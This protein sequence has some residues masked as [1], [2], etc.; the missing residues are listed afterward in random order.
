MISFIIRTHEI[1]LKQK[2]RSLFET[3]LIKNIKRH[4]PDAT[5]T[6]LHRRF[7]LFLPSVTKQTYTILGSIAGIANF[8]E[9]TI[10]SY[11]W[12]DIEKT[13]LA[14]FEQELAKHTQD[15]LTFCVKSHRGNK[16]YPLNSNEMNQKLGSLIIDRYP[17]LSV[18]LRNPDILLELDVLVEQKVIVFIHKQTGLGGL[19]VGTATHSL[20]FLSS[21]IDSP[22]A[23]WLMLTRGCRVSY[24]NFDSFPFIG[25]KT[26][27]K[28]I[29]LTKILAKYQPQTDLYIAPFANIQKAIRKQCK[30]SMRTI[31]YRRFMYFVANEFAK[32]LPDVSTYISGEA[33]GQVASQTIENLQ[34]TNAASEKL[35]LRPLIGFAKDKI[36]EHAKLINTYETSIEPLPDSCTLFQPQHPET[37]AR[38]HNALYEEEKLDSLALI[39]ECVANIEK[40]YFTTKDALYI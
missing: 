6:K 12:E 20:S 9:V 14:T 30:E 33:L 21:G 7:L 17:S 16:Q 15:N 39:E 13:A 35:V 8:S 37:K 29:H 19:P 4:L 1:S 32:T 18:N 10:T 28:V 3:Q 27:H 2:N 31:L 11:E 5:V 38:I 22:V 36:I 26:K 34:C 23:S 24:L 25:E 40:H